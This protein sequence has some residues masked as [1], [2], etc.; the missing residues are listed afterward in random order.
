MVAWRRELVPIYPAAFLA[1]RSDAE[2]IELVRGLGRVGVALPGVTEEFPPYR[3]TRRST[4]A[5]RKRKFLEEAVAIEQTSAQEAGML[6]YMARVLVQATM[7]HSSTPAVDGESWRLPRRSWWFSRLGVINKL[8]LDFRPFNSIT[9]QV[10][11][12]LAAKGMNV[13]PSGL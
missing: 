1:N 5:D 8:L 13:E 3:V 6:G 7:P 11:S 9:N 2:I 12:D 4:A 10:K